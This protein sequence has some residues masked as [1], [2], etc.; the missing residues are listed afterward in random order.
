[1]AKADDMDMTVE[2]EHLF[3]VW[4][5]L[6]P[7]QRTALVDNT[8]RREFNAGDHIHAGS[9]DCIGILLI[10]RGTLRAYMLSEEG[11]EITLFTMAAGESCVLSATCVLPLI[12]FD[13]FIDAQ[14]KMDLLVISPMYYRT[15][16][17]ANPYVEA[18]TYRETAERFSDVMWVMEQVLFVSFDKRLAAFLLD[19]AVPAADGTQRRPTIQLTHDAIARHLGSAREVVS[20]MLKYFEREGLVEL[21]RGTITLKDVPA[22]EAL[23]GR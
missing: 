4:E 18:Y 9:N 2:V 5:H 10:R 16:L 11:R 14:T 8:T 17:D 1:M 15:L 23:S 19:R 3:P 12:T 22:L 21:S 13:V 6:T 7:A 20:R